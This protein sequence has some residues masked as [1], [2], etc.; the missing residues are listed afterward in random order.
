MSKNA[1]FLNVCVL[2]Q[3]KK[4]ASCLGVLLR[5]KKKKERERLRDMSRY[6]SVL[7]DDRLVDIPIRPASLSLVSIRDEEKQRERKRERN[8]TTLN[9]R[10]VH[11]TTQ[12][13]THEEMDAYPLL[14]KT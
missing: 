5:K 9:E 12:H 3:G 6:V 13:T 14:S 8:I 2:R 1:F 10:V 11:N 4:Q 7:F